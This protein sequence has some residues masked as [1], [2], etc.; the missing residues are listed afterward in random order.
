MM[1]MQ[2]L[3]LPPVV[4]LEKSLRLDANAP[5]L[6]GLAFTAQMAEGFLTIPGPGRREAAVASAFRTETTCIAVGHKRQANGPAFSTARC[7]LGRSPF[8][9][10]FAVASRR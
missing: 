1:T 7:R 6:L 5:L 4:Q 2:P 10:R 8:A 9:E 3:V